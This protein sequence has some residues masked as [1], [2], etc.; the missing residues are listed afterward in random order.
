MR[1]GLHEGCSGARGQGKNAHLE[2]LRD[3]EWGIWLKTGRRKD[4]GVTQ[5]S[6]VPHFGGGG[7]GS[8]GRH[9]PS[10]ELG[11]DQ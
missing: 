9:L 10:G 1:T 7:G 3:K 4:Q 11:D 8:N 6:K 5:N 2:T